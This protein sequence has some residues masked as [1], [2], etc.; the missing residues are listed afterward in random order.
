MGY[1]AQYQK[2]AEKYLE[3]QT[4][5]RRLRIMNAVDA[6]PSGDVVKMKGRAGYR[7]VVGDFRV[8]F[9]YTDKIDD[10]GKTIIDIITIGPRG[11]VYKK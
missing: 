2:S 6:L 11:D 1:S 3:A 10:D 7:L 8:L 4:K 5:V 9:D